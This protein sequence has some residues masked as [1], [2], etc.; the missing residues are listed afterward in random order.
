MPDASRPWLARA[1]LTLTDYRHVSPLFDSEA[2]AASAY[3]SLHVRLSGSPW[4]CDAAQIDE[5]LMNASG[6]FSIDQVR[7]IHSSPT[8]RLAS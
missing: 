1:K 7:A 8:V 6:A 4:L 5:E 2:S 3:V